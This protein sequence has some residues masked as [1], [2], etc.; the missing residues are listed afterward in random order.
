MNLKF[1]FTI[2]VLSPEET[3][4]HFIIITVVTADDIAIYIRLYLTL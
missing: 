4:K 1:L 2:Q 3:K